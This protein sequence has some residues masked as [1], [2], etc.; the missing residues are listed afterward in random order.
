MEQ[1][2][3]ATAALFAVAGAVILFLVLSI[4]VSSTANAADADLVSGTSASTPEPRTAQTVKGSV[5]KKLKIYKAASLGKRTDA[6]SVVKWKTLTPKYCK[7]GTYKLLAQS[8]PGKC[9][10]TAQAPA[11][12]TAERLPPTTYIVKIVR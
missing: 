6:G 3:R 2:R 1:L 8:K 12:G 4:A 10:I 11:K 5:V 7:I 9:K